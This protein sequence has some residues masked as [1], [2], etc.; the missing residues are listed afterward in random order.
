VERNNGKSVKSSKLAKIISQAAFTKADFL[1]VFGQIV[2]HRV[3]MPLI[4][5]SITLFIYYIS[6]LA[7]TKART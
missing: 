5:L 7:W 1:L 2:F 4:C 6:V 3:S